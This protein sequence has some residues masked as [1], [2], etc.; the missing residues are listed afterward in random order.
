[1]SAD[2]DLAG[3]P[4]W[5]I[6]IGH[7]QWFTGVGSLCA[8]WL[9]FSRSSRALWNGCLKHFRH[10]TAM[11]LPYGTFVVYLSIL[12]LAVD[13]QNWTGNY[14]HSGRSP[15]N[16]IAV[17]HWFLWAS[18]FH[19]L[20][21]Y[22]KGCLLLVVYIVLLCMLV[23]RVAGTVSSAATCPL[24]VAKTRL[25]SSL[26]AAGHMQTRPTFNVSGGSF[27]ATLHA[28]PPRYGRPTVSIGF[29]HCLRWVDKCFM[30][31]FVSDI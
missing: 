25:Q 29:Y 31:I 20:D 18:W 23:Y 16:L 28:P 2:L 24:D 21:F 17:A 1:M 15:F 3:A 22:C 6:S 8:C 7:E 30:L 14:S 11:R 5:A 19:L 4:D 27:M 12:M 13:W 26:I 9:D 10:A